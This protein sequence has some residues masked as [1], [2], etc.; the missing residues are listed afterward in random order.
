MKNKIFALR[1]E[2]QLY[3]P[4]LCVCGWSAGIASA[5]EITVS[6]RVTYEAR[7]G[8]YVNRGADDGLRQGTAGTLRFENGRVLEFDVLHVARTSALLHLTS[9]FP[10]DEHYIGRTVQLTFKQTFAREE[11]E[12]A[13]RPLN[14]KAKSADDGD[15]VPLL[16]PPPWTIGLPRSRNISHGQ[17]RLHQM[18]QTDN[19]DSLDYSLTRLGSSGS[20][21]KLHGSP[22][23]LEWSG[24]L[25]YR[26]GDAYRHHPDHEKLRLDV[27]LASFYRSFGEYNFLRLGRFLPRELPGIGYVDGV[28]RQISHTDSWRLGLI[29][30]LKPDRSNL[31]PFGNEPIVATYA[32]Y[33]TG[34]RDGKH[35]IATVGLL[36]SVYKGQ[37]DRLAMLVD[38]RA[39]W[40][41]SLTV[42]STTEVAFDV[43][44]AETRTGTKLNRLDVSAVSTVSEF[45]TLRA[46]MDHWERPDNQSE[47]DL[48]SVE[49]ER[50]FDRG[51][52]RYWVGSDQYL[53][54][55]LK[56]FE[57]ITFIDAPE[58]DYDPR[59]QLGLTRTGIFAWPQASVT[60]TFY[61]LDT[62]NLDGYGGRLS[63]YLPVLGH[64]L[65]LQ[66]IAGF[67]MLDVRPQSR[68]FEVNYLA[69]R[70]N[71]RLSGQWT[72]FGGLTH[73]YGDRIDSTFADIGLRF[74]W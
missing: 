13:G 50:L 33:E 68:E 74:A 48:L 12:K 3:L 14:E 30:G 51:F 11:D 37:A 66:P 18:L 15:F 63:A 47:R 57:Q 38:Q 49:D 22:W 40:D 39:S 20:L 10:E 44:G 7:E 60:A 70:V 58:F 43:G 72:L 36:G 52:W 61:N 45:L 24:D 27:Y 31:D 4:A 53:P 16:A 28:Q 56:L 1:L 71:G 26:T 8:I 32:T 67:R 62:Q 69:L 35:Y 21:E 54:G 2:I 73:S 65:F 29:A 46:G 25:A 59:W 64:K 9:P 19:Q 41:S 23:S 17:I 6:C 42:Y 5:E 55:N 34:D